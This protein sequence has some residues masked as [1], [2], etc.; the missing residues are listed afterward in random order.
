M[1]FSDSDIVS[2]I[3]LAAIDSEIAAV[4]NSTKPP[5]SIDGSGGICE[6]AWRECSHSI[7]S[8]QQ[9][10]ST[11][12]AY[13]GF[14]GAHLGAIY[15]TGIPSVTQGRIRLSQVVAHEAA[16][17]AAASPIQTWLTY[18]AL[19]MFYRNA[20]SRKGDDRYQEKMDRFRA[21]AQS[22]WRTLRTLGLPCISRPLEAPGA[23]HSFRAGTWTAANISSAAGGSTNAVQPLSVAITYYDSS[24]YVSQSSNGNAE[25]APSAVVPFSLAALSLLKVDITSLYPPTGTDDPVGV[26]QGT[27]TPLTAT[28]WNLWAGP[29][30][31]DPSAVPTLYLQ[32][33]GI[34]IAT[35][36]WTL[37]AD[38]TFSGSPLGQ[39]QYPDRALTFQNVVMRG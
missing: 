20:S 17:A 16:Y 33:E 8:A 26:S 14:T 19:Y 7:L 18:T 24:K 29:A 21:D 30:A 9:V 35:K 13:P 3:N 6:Q 39:G 12:L 11:Y 5:I 2:A 23:K 15:N 32:K 34:P 38:P 4:A 10:Y 1:L 37:A 31:S 36:T 27:L 22:A 25:S 28:H